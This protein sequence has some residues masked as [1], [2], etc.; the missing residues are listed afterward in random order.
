MQSS[1]RPPKR[2]AVLIS[3]QVRSDNGDLEKISRLCKQVDADV[4]ICVWRKRGAKGFGG[5]QG[6]LQ[7][8]RV[9]GTRLAALMPRNWIGANMRK[10][11]PK[12]DH[13]FPDLG[14]LTHQQ[15]AEIFPGATTELVEEKPD[16]SI[17]YMDSNSLRMLYMINKCNGLKR[18]AEIHGSFRYDIVIRHRPDVRLDYP[19]AI[20]EFERTGKVVFPKGNANNPKQLHDIY[21]AGSSKQDDTLSGLYHRALETRV[22]GWGGIHHELLDWTITHNI[23]LETY[24]CV[25]SGIN[26]ASFQDQQTQEKVAGNFVMAVE[27][28]ALD[29]ENAGGEVF[30]HVYGALFM[31]ALSN[32]PIAR[33]VAEAT[34]KET[35]S[36]DIPKRQK[37]FL[38]QASGWQVC[39]DL[40]NRL[41]TR[42][43]AFLVTVAVDF[44]THNQNAGMW[45]AGAF[46][47]FFGQDQ[48]V[49]EIT[50]LLLEDSN[51][52]TLNSEFISRYEQDIC[53]LAGISQDDLNA[54][55]KDVRN[56]ILANNLNWRW[57][58]RGLAAEKADDCILTLT[59]ELLNRNI[60]ARDLVNQSIGIHR[61]T[62]RQDAWRALLETSVAISDQAIAF[63]DLGIFHERL[64]EIDQAILNYRAALKKE[65]CPQWVRKNLQAI[66][67]KKSEKPL[68]ISGTHNAP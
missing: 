14:A 55:V 43:Q 40:E 23:D 66:E 48:S 61:L 32:T 3:G 30:C 50:T 16:M 21:W 67:N 33:S 20:A 34:Y 54:V 64:G 5:G 44:M 31:S 56:H 60:Y 36:Q 53:V 57:F 8:S 39:L 1:P 41:Q 27:N 63:A 12:S 22:E 65:H 29:I 24:G 49:K 9:F 18:Q 6:L 47:E 52:E 51:S 45:S 17:P 26:D 7:L 25:L 38:L 68:H 13:I 4:Y 58:V 37:L 42:L 2:I 28:R 35:I 10:V 59:D 11:F 15:L 62:G 19:K 46:P